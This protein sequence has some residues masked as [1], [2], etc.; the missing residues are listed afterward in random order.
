MAI[1]LSSQK[2]FYFLFGLAIWAI[3][4]SQCEYNKVLKSDS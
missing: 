3:G 4:K 2:L 1:E